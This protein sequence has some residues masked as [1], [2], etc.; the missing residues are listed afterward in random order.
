MLQ[1]VDLNHAKH[2]IHI[3]NLNNV[4][5]RDAGDTH[6]VSFHMNGGHVVPVNVD[7]A[8]AEALF[9]KLGHIQYG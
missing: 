8:T 4:V 9:K 2:S 6:V 5:I 1:F 3:A 7:R